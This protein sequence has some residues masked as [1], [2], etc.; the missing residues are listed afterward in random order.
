VSIVHN[1]THLAMFVYLFGYF[2]TICQLR[3][4]I[5]LFDDDV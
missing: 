4:F 3:I 2:M 1:G 5:P